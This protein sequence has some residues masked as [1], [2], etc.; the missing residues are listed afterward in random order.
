MND[1]LNLVPEKYRT[2]LL[3][4]IAISPYITRAFH[5]LKSGGGLRGVLSA[6]WLGTNTPKPPTDKPQP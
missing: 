6:I 4:A 5:A 2:E 1:I 3:I